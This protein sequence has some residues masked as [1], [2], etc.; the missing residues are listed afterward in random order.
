MTGT[1]TFLGAAWLVHARPPVAA[2]VKTAIA[3][4]DLLILHLSWRKNWPSWAIR[5]QTHGKR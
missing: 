4:R 2:A 5:K 1:C 3:K